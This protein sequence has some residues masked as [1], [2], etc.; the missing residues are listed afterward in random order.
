ME[1]EEKQSPVKSFVYAMAGAW[2]IYAS[3]L[4]EGH[5]GDDKFGTV[6]LG[7]WGACFWVGGV[8]NLMVDRRREKAQKGGSR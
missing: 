5:L 6:A 4:M 1:D 2:A 7:I 3:L 8:G